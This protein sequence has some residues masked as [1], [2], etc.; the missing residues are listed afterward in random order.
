MQRSRLRSHPLVYDLTCMLLQLSTIAMKS[1]SGHW[2]SLTFS[3]FLFSHSWSPGD[4]WC[5]VFIMHHFCR[6]LILLLCIFCVKFI[7]LL[8]SGMCCGLCV[9]SPIYFQNYSWVLTS[10]G[11]DLIQSLSVQFNLDK[12]PPSVPILFIKLK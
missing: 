6:S 2:Y 12:S 9:H 7:N 5:A 11:G 4:C 10:G 3:A 8:R 1:R